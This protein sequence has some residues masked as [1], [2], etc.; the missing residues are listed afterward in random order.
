MNVNVCNIRDN[1]FNEKFLDSVMNTGFAVITHHGID[2][3]LIKETQ[4]AWKEFFNKKSM[5]K[6]EFVNP[7]DPNMGFKGFGSEKAVGSNIADLKEFYH[8][9]PGQ[10]LPKETAA[11]TEKLFNLL[12][13]HLSGQILQ[14]LDSVVPGT[15]YKKACEESDNTIL[16]TLYYP[17][18]KDIKVEPGAVRGSAHEDINFITLLVAASS[19][20]LQV[21]DKEGNWHNVPFEENSVVVNIGDQLQLA[22]NRLFKSTTHRVV[23]SDDSSTDRISMPLFVHP[24]GSTMLAPGITAQQYLN[25]RIA[26][27]YVKVK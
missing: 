7:I 27:I 21:L 16:R 26:Q 24:R 13:G 19:S 9:R 10:K 1:D 15:T 23:N 14:V 25:E 22:S 5:Y 11:V 20:G 6:A 17:A 8:F 12:N 3:G 2:F 18:L 4:A